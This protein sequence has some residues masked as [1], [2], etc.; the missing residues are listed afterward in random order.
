MATTKQKIMLYLSSYLPLYFLLF[1]NIFFNIDNESKV[2]RNINLYTLARFENLQVSIYAIIL[3]TLSCISIYNVFSLI[4]FKKGNEEILIESQFSS[5]G[6][7]I[8]SYIMTYIVPMLSIDPFNLWSLLSNTFLFVII[9]VI[10]ISNNLI[11]LNPVVA[12]LGFKI[13]KDDEGSI[14]L[15][16]MNIGDLDAAKK[17]NTEVM[18]YEIDANIYMLKEIGE[19]KPSTR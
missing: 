7:N 11:F 16:K 8:I 1:L 10:Y 19:E 4:V 17:S 15:T 9:G 2:E 13:F 12:I 6:D 5:M 18:K 3:V 14:V